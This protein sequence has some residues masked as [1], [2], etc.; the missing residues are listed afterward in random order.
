MSE[1]FEPDICFSQVALSIIRRSTIHSLAQPDKHFNLNKDV[2]PVVEERLLHPT[3]VVRRDSSPARAGSRTTV[4]V[5]RPKFWTSKW[6]GPPD[7]GRRS[8]TSTSTTDVD[9]FIVEVGDV[10]RGHV[11]L[12]FESRLDGFLGIIL[13]KR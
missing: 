12:I 6:G 5:H 13:N 3:L 2:I 1:T 4:T 7:Q 9:F 11:S 10:R 8:V